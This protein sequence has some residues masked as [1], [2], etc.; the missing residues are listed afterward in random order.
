MNEF[1]TTNDRTDRGGV[2]RRTFGLAL[3]GCLAAAIALPG[4]AASAVRLSRGGPVV[5][6]H[7]D[8]PW[9]D[10]SGRDTPYRPPVTASRDTPDNETL[11]RLGHFL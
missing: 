5:G 3:G 11:A 8:A 6:F 1:S 10:P 9:L 7:A 4:M 2:T